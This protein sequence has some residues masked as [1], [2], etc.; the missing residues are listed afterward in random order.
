MIIIDNETFDVG[1]IDIKRKAKIE[2]QELGTTQDGI[3][4]VV[5]VGT[6]FDYVVT[7]ATKKMNVSEYNRLYEVLTN[8]VDYHNVT[9]P[10]NDTTISFK[11]SISSA[12]DSIVANY[13]NFRK[14]S[15]L[16]IT[17]ESLE[18]QKVAE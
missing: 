3:N 14:W 15:S 7:F 2:K 4:H 5:A 18:L 11:A 13:N 12:D 16:Q 17:F 1:I 8:P 6:R 10:Y 9:M